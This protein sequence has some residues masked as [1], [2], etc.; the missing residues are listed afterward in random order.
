M[1]LALPALGWDPSWDYPVSRRR[2]V[3]VLRLLASPCRAEA[4]R[5][6][7]DGT[8]EAVVGVRGRLRASRRSPSPATGAPSPVRR[9]TTRSS[10]ACYRGV[11]SLVRKV[12]GQRTEG[13]R[14]GQR[15]RRARLRPRALGEPAA[16]SS[17]RSP[18][19]GS[20]AP[21]SG[22]GAHESDL[23]DDPSRHPRRKLARDRRRRRR[24][25]GLVVRRRRSRR[26]AC[27]HRR[28]RD[29]GGHRAVG[30]REV[31]A[32]QRA[33]RR[34]AARDDGGATTT[35]VHA[36]RRRSTSS[37]CPMAASCSTRPRHARGLAVG[38]RTRSTR[39]SATSGVRRRL[40]L[41]RLRAPDRARCAVLAAVDASLLDPDRLASW[42]KL[43]RGSRNS[44][45][46]RTYGSRSRSASAGPALSKGSR[47]RIRLTVDG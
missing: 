6:A 38:R 7:S 43:Q 32:R 11:P 41:R 15:R 44:R 22:R 14:R 36:P 5:G 16:A 29:P 2:P 12:A 24:A 33:R 34:A 10:S 42:R 37:R 46:N 28:R 47:G 39:R 21:A 40:P 26:G 25:G 19:C 13:G 35:S 30:C 3:P 45:A 18:S 8:D 31:D 20:R 27:P 17:A 4:T 1:V 9:P 23:D